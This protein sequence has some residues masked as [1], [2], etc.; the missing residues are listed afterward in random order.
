MLGAMLYDFITANSAEILALSREKLT[1]RKVPIPT[2]MELTEGLPVFLAQLVTILRGDTGE[3]SRDHDNVVASARLHGEQLQRMGVSVGQV[4]H[5]YGSICQSVTELAD[6]QHVAIT[7][8]EFQTFNRCL[9]DAIA[10]AV[11]T[12]GA[13]RDHDVGATQL[14]FL[15]HE[16]R[17]LLSTAMLTYGALSRGSVGIQGSTGTLHGRSL[18]RMKVLIDRTLAE[19]RLEVGIQHR[20]RVSV[21]ELIHE[22]ESVASIEVQDP[23]MRLSVEAGSRDV[24]VLADHQILASVIANLLQN[25]FKFS[26]PG[27]LV[28]VRTHTAGARVLIEV[29]DECGGLAPGDPEQLFT[30]FEQRN[31]SKIGLGLGLA[32]S[33]KGVRASDGDIRVRDLPGS[34]CVFTIDLPTAAPAGADAEQ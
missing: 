13:Q 1:S 5:D 12:F 7:A 32:I 31:V 15:A 29:G 10:E 2:S 14:G 6:K 4:V 11:T 8:E 3:E 21:A 27:G 20:E 33:R 24:V 34:G 28:T 26:K 9:D 30:P 16:M 19:A 17:N 25:A 23:E 22:I 18:R